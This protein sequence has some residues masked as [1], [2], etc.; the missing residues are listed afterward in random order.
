MNN[1]KFIEQ[2]KLVHA[3]EC[4]DGHFERFVNIPWLVADKISL[5][6]AHIIQRLRTLNFNVTQ[7]NVSRIWTIRYLDQEHLFAYVESDLTQWLT[8]LNTT[9]ELR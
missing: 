5:T 3:Q 6:V 7:F 2:T 4:K 9:D 8:D 1:L